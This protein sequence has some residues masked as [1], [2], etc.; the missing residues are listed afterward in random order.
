MSSHMA[1]REDTR[2]HEL[3]HHLV[4]INIIHLH[5]AR[6]IM[7][8]HI[9]LHG[10]VFNMDKLASLHG[11]SKNMFPFAF[12]CS[13]LLQILKTCH[14]D[15]FTATS[16]PSYG[17]CMAHSSALCRCSNTARLRSLQS[18]TLISNALCWNVYRKIHSSECNECSFMEDITWI[19]RFITSNIEKNVFVVR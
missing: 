7:T 11:H 3:W 1:C 18:E 10:A 5:L 9:T 4:P 2:W 19:S 14:L 17:A 6:S 16:P 13:D 8:E 12:R 15:M